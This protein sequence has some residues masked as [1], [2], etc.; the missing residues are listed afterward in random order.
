LDESYDTP[1]RDHDKKRDDAPNHERFAFFVRSL[2]VAIL[3]E[4]D[5]S[6]QEC[7][8]SK[9]NEERD[10]LFNP[11]ENGTQEIQYRVRV[12]ARHV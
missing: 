10:K 3:D 2:I 8:H 7:R 5:Q 9:R 12:E 11:P 6:P 1:E 4:F